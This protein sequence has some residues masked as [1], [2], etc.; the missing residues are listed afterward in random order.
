MGKKKPTG[1]IEILFDD[2]GHVS[3]DI[4]VGMNS[5]L[6]IALMGLE[7]FLKSNTNLSIEDVRQLIDEE[8]DGIEKRIKPKIKDAD[9]IDAELDDSED[10]D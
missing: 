8:K 4:N 7:G 10:Q 3:F 1:K 6:I 9:V 5:Q 2:K